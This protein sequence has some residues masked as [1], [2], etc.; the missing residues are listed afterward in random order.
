[1]LRIRIGFGE[2]EE[3]CRVGVYA[4]T[5]KNETT[6]QIPI[7]RNKRACGAGP[8][9]S[10]YQIGSNLCSLRRSRLA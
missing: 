2:I 4:P 9:V 7:G 5:I 8:F 1:M 6:R 10:C 3:S